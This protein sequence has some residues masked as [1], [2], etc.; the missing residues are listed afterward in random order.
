MAVRRY[1]IGPVLIVRQWG[2]LVLRAAAN[3]AMVRST[4]PPGICRSRR[5]RA[6]YQVANHRLG[7]FIIE[8]ACASSSSCRDRFS[9]VGMMVSNG[10]VSD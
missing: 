4:L 8:K 10:Q 6:K 1:R 9:G 3:S 2:E 7:A 5:E